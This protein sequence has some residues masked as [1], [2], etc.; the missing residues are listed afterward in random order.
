MGF[1][2]VILSEDAVPNGAV[3]TYQDVKKCARLFKE[4]HYNIDESYV[5]R[6]LPHG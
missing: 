5:D 3:E 2:Y 4:N 1:G 6:R